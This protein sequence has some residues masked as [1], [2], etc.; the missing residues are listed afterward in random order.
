MPDLPTRAELFQIGADEV[1]ARSA[2]R[3]VG[4]RISE[5]EIRTEGS[6]INIA[7]ASSSAMAEEV[8]RQTAEGLRDLLLDGA[9]DEA[10]DRFIADRFSPTVVRKDAS[11]ALVTVS[12]SRTAGPLLAV[13]I[14][15]GQRLRALDGIEFETTQAVSLTAG[16][17]GPV[18]TAA[19]AR[20]AGTAGNVAAATITAFAATPPDTNLLVTN[21]SFASGGDDRETDA[22]LRE[23]ARDF[24][25]QARRGTSAAIEFGALTVA[26][27]RQA[28]SI[29]EV[30]LLGIPTGRVSLFIA[31]AQ[32]QANAALVAAVRSALVEFRAEGIIVDIFGSTPNFVTILYR[33]RFEAGVD[34]TEALASIRL[35]TVA[36]VNALRPTKTL[37]VSLLFTAARSVPGVIVLQDAVVAPVG[38]LVPA[39][40]EVIRTRADLVDAE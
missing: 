24:F 4:Q 14:P 30:D 15:L 9:E 7:I 19:E 18:T 22:R 8:V 32:G 3:P 6:D 12:F 17:L 28:V 34:S 38:D 1:L 21:P 10:L 5:E 11:Q 23:R 29:E 2:A 16:S 26:G 20:E 25:R 33:L 39:T 13:T 35:A 27:I 31:D 40:G 36:A 37:E